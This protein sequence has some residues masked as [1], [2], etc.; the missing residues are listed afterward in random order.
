[1]DDESSCWNEPELALSGGSLEKLDAFDISWLRSK[2]GQNVHQNI[3]NSHIR[4][5]T[6]ILHF[7]ICL[8]IIKF[9]CYGSQEDTC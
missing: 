2:P 9:Q 6:M 7:L 1:M 5:M 8:K 3:V 4:P